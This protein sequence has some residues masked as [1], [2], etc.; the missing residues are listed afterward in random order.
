[1]AT[2]SLPKT[3]QMDFNNLALMAQD[4]VAT[5]TLYSGGAPVAPAS[6]VT[7]TAASVALTVADNAFRTTVLS[8]VDGMTITVPAAAATDVGTKYRIWLGASTTSN[9]YVIS[10][11]GNDLFHGVAILGDSTDGTAHIWATAS[12]TNP[13]TL[14]G[15]ANA[16]GGTI[17]TCIE[18]ECI[19][20]DTYGVRITGDAAGAEATPFSNV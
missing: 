14:G 17:G 15:T 12:N 3:K 2:T 13:I 18:L 1:M 5:G 11:T 6:L 19:A 7:S 4:V 9:A 8:K 10:A 20:A 16:T